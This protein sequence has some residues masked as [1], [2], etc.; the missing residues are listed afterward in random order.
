METEN[1]INNVLNS[2]DGMTKVIPSDLLF[3]KIQNR[4][5]NNKISTHWIWLA[6]A[7]FTILIS[8]NIKIVFGESNKNQIE[9]LTST[10]AK[11][12]QLY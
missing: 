5:R 12:N 8:L 1:W 2:T 10:I 3:Y 9:T 11:S 6:A 4:I 7:S